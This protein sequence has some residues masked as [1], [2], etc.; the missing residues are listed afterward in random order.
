MLGV[1]H[2][3]VKAEL[4]DHFDKFGSGEHYRD[5]VCG[6]PGL[7][8]GFHAVGLQETGSCGLAPVSRQFAHTERPWQVSLQVE[9]DVERSDSIAKSVGILGAPQQKHCRVVSDGGIDLREVQPR[10]WDR[11][12]VLCWALSR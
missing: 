5:A 12:A 10:S 7:D 3:P 6:F 1:E 11:F 8:E 9:Y 4:A 2:D